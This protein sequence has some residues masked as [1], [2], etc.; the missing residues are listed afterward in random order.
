MVFVEGAGPERMRQLAEHLLVCDD[1]SEVVQQ[2][3]ALHHWHPN[4]AAG[5]TGATTAEEVRSLHARVPRKRAGNG[6]T[7][8]AIAAA[9]LATAGVVSWVLENRSDSTAAAGVER[10]ATSEWQLQPID[11]SSIDTSE[12]LILSAEPSGGLNPASSFRFAIYDATSN[13]VWSSQF[14]AQPQSR[15]PTEVVDA[16][17]AGEIYLWRAEERAGIDLRR[18]PLTSFVAGSSDDGPPR[19]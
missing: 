18:S 1:C 15:V 8:L 3:R 13:Q 14:I 6:A 7:W 11:G 4:A 17:V 9:L 2:L 16:L 12:P 5:Q 10:G 19:P